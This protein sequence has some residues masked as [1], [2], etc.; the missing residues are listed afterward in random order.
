MPE[1]IKKNIAFICLSICLFVFGRGF[2]QNPSPRET[3]SRVTEHISNTVFA[4]SESVDS[5][6]SDSLLRDSTAVTPPPEKKKAKLDAVVNYQSKDSIVFTG[7]GIGYLFGEGKVTYIQTEL[8]ADYIRMNLDSSMVYASGSRDSLGNKVGYPVFKDKGD[9]YDSESI[10]YNFNTGKGY[11]TNVITQQGEGYITSGRTKRM[12]DGSFFMVDGKYTTCDLHDDPHFY[13]N[14]TRAKVRPQ[15]NVVTGPAYLV[16]EDVPLPVAFPFAFFPF[17]KKY[18]SGVIMPKYGDEMTRGFYLRQGGYYFAINDNVDLSVTGDLY[19]KGSWGLQATSAYIKRYKY[20]GA[21]NSKYIKTVTGDK[22]AG[23]Y[24][25]R[26]D[27]SINWQ[28][29]QDSKASP[30]TTLSANVDFSTSGYNRNELSSIYNANSYTKNNKS[31]SINYGIRLFEN[32]L[33]INASTRINQNSA[34]SII[35]WSMPSLSISAPTFYPFKRKNPVGDERWYEKISLSYQGNLEN[36]IKTKENLLF[37]SSLIKDWRNGMSHSIPISASFTLFNNIN[38]SPS[39]SYKERWYTSKT[40]QSYDDTGTLVRDT[41]YGFNRVYDYSF[42]VGAS[43]TLYGFYKPVPSVFGDKIEMIRHTFKPSISYSMTPDFGSSRYGYYDTATYTDPTT[44]KTITKDYS[45]YEG[46]L[47]GAPSRGKSGTIS[48]GL[49]NTLEMKVKSDKDSTGIKK[50]SIFDQLSIS[51]GYNLAADSL[52]WSYISLRLAVKITK[53][54]NLNVSATFDPYTY[55]V[56]NN[57]AVKVNVTQW[58]KNHIP[59]RLTSMTFSI[60]TVSLNNNTFKK[61]KD[62]KTNTETGSETSDDDPLNPRNMLSKGKGKTSDN[63][64]ENTSDKMLDSDGYAK[65][66]V[67]WSFNLNYNINLGTN[68]SSFNY[69]KK[70]YDLKWDQSLSFGGTIQFTKNWNFGFQSNYNFDAKK[71]G[72]TSCTISRDLH[73][74]TMSAGFVPIGPTQSYNFIISVKS[75][76]LRDLKYEQSASPYNNMNWY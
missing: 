38:I 31:S 47:Y 74:W 55:E 44:L 29:S 49:D 36:S 30:N 52:N 70:E 6:R 18:S 39:V 8:T 22:L 35:D 63:T 14:L 46:Y 58:Q 50:I 15:K 75:A 4:K 26:T 66:E 64:P 60:P 33:S 21:F 54:Y 65:W 73:C 72:Y 67:P 27:F 53:S 43:T 3:G 20:R 32:A 25:E 57:Q 11:I 19:T 24:L 45:Y 1:I 34:D 13:L 61:K 12:S 5:L 41:I 10:L 28:H 69:E 42:S 68:Y 2:S 48:F 76:L 17:T 9:S 40:K 16:M 7:S 71:I 59:G 23:D 56:Y 37:K 62:N 51:S